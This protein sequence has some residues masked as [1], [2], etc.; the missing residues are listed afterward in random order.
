MTVAEVLG[1]WPALV[2]IFVRRK[3]ACPG[4]DMAV[5]MTL[6]EAAE[7]YGMDDSFIEELRSAVAATARL[8][9]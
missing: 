2:S 4:C 3:M 6:G 7:V 1:A 9:A 5:H 8:T